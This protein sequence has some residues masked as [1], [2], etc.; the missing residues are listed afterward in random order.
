MHSLMFGRSLPQRQLHFRSSFPSR[1]GRLR[2][3]D[4]Q[5]QVSAISLARLAEPTTDQLRMTPVMTVAQLLE[6]CRYHWDLPGH[7]LELSDSEG[8]YLLN[9]D[10]ILRLLEDSEPALT[11]H[12][13][14]S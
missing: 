10:T 11:L 2:D 3:S 13:R 5:V 8:Y 7:R 6:Q 12:V 1:G 14:D 4:G 9:S